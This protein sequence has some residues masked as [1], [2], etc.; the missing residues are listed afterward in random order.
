MDD[1]SPETTFLQHP[2]AV[3]VDTVQPFALG[4]EQ[5]VVLHKV[6]TNVHLSAELHKGTGPEKPCAFIIVSTHLC[7][8]SMRWSLKISDLQEKVEWFFYMFLKEV[9]YAH[10]VCI[11]WIQNTVKS[12]T[13]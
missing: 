2:A 13:L 10:L 4:A 3:L 1:V 7:T 11:Y 8:Y 12:N 9:S 5:A 6:L